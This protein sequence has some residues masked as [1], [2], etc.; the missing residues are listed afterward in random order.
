VAAHALHHAGDADAARQQ[1]VCHLQ[2]VTEATEMPKLSDAR[3]FASIWRCSR[4]QIA[5]GL[6]PAVS[7]SS[8][9]HISYA[10]MA[11]AYS[12]AAC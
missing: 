3:R 12:V 1:L 2:K 4:F 9:K 8:R 6:Q 10:C 11:E 7:A 5:S